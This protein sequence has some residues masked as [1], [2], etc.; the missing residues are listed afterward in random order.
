MRTCHL[1][2]LCSAIFAFGLVISSKPADARRT[3]IDGG[4]IRMIDGYC[5]PN[6][7]GTAS[8]QPQ[9]LPFELQIGG[10]TYDS[11]VV[12]G[13]TT[14]S[15]GA[16]IDFADATGTLSAYGIPVF[17]PLIDN[18]L[19]DL[20]NMFTGLFETDTF[21]S[22]AF[23]SSSNS[24]TVE[25]FP[26]STN[27]FCG[28]LSID[29]L[30]AGW[31]QEQLDDAQ[32]RYTFGLTLT[33]VEYGFSLVYFYNYAANSAAPYGFYLPGAAQLQTAGG[34]IDSRTWFFNSDGQL[35]GQVPEPG[36]WAMMLIGFALVGFALRRR[37]RG[38]L[39]LH[40]IAQSPI[41][42]GA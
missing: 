25:W 1:L 32:T 9:P 16:P 42:A 15:L 4:F 31:T 40:Q 27:V 38:D 36:T 2:R 6:V 23:T 19:V 13:N 8:C 39:R 30:P 28:P 22:A 14:L 26:C 17:S 11:F 34:S 41:L 12:N 33:A 24:L 35:V 20:P 18:T 21:Y 7:V 37:K 29:E 10:V 5:A 3:V